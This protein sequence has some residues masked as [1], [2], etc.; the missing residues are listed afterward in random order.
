MLVITM[1]PDR[2]FEFE[3][4]LKNRCSIPLSS[5]DY[6]LGMAGSKV[7]VKK[8]VLVFSPHFPFGV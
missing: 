8:A 3:P 4:K 1:T 6:L 2:V 5:P 7:K